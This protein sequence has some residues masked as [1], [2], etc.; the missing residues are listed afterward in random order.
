MHIQ[1][2]FLVLLKIDSYWGREYMRGGFGVFLYN[3]DA[4]V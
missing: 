2:L 1:R 4:D 3:A